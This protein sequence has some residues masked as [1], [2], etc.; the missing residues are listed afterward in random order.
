MA[1]VGYTSTQFFIQHLCLKT[2]GSKPGLSVIFHNSE[3][4]SRLN[5]ESCMKNCQ[6]Y[7]KS[8]FGH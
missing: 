3:A 8:Q 7:V 6:F 5:A 2:A 1:H 4:V